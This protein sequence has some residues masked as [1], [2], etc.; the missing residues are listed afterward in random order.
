MSPLFLLI[1][2]LA[3]PPQ[4][5]PT[6]LAIGDLVEDRSHGNQIVEVAGGLAG[7][8]G[9]S[10]QIPAAGATPVAI[11][12]LKLM[13]RADGP[14]TCTYGPG[15]IVDLNLMNVLDRGIVTRAVGGFCQVK[16]SSSVSY[17]EFARLK[18]VKPA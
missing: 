6:M 9:Y 16:T 10:V 14:V 12:F 17:E 3:Q 18:L 2:V 15:D 13:A 1:A 8:G 7:A 5:L 11:H 4:R